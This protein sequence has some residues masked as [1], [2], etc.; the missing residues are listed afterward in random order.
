[1]N[2]KTFKYLL[3]LVCVCV[4]VC[5]CL[6]KNA[7]HVCEDAKGTHKSMSEMEL[8]ELVNIPLGF[9]VECSENAESAGKHWAILVPKN[10]CL[11]I[12]PKI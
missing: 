2:R 10:M 11:K 6:S 8:Q 3:F 1:M 4:C 12:Q 9:E 7:W 5:V